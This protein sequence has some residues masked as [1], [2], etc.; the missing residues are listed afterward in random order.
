MVLLLLSALWIIVLT[1]VISLCIA[2]R[3]GDLQ[4]HLSTSPPVPSEPDPNSVVTIT[5]VQRWGVDVAD[6]PGDHARHHA[7]HMA[8]LTH[9]PQP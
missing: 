2:A 3:N 4:H 6:R 7:H 5:R 9:H 8:V 1:L